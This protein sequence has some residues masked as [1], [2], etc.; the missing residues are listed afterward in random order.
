MNRKIN[1]NYF[2]KIQKGTFYPPM[3]L[4][5]T[6]MEVN[7][8]QKSKKANYKLVGQIMENRSL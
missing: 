8:Y 6:R 5:S 1:I 4:N 2:S 7:N 3:C